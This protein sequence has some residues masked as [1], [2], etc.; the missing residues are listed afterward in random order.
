MVLSFGNI[1]SDRELVSKRLRPLF[2][3]A[4]STLSPPLVFPAIALLWNSA[5]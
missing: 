5:D 2:V 1:V 4:P 3:G